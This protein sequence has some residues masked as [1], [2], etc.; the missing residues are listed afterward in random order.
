MTVDECALCDRISTDVR[1]SP[2]SDLYL[3]RSCRVENE[4]MSLRPHEIECP[5]C[6]AQPGQWCHRHGQTMPGPTLYC[7]ARIRQARTTQ[8]QTRKETPK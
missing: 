4:P 7:V 2:A 5:G 8:T 1:H 3:C 6:Q